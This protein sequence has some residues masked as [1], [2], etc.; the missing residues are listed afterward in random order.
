MLSSNHHEFPGV[1]LEGNARSSSPKIPCWTFTSFLLLR[2][3][4]NQ[5]EN[6]L[7]LTKK[8][9]KKPHSLSCSGAIL[10]Y[11]YAIFRYTL[12]NL[13]WNPKKNGSLDQMFFLFNWGDFWDSK[14]LI[15]VEVWN[16]ENAAPWF[17]PKGSPCMVYLSTWK[18]WKSTIHGSVNIPDR[19]S[20]GSLMGLLQNSATN[21]AI[22][23]SNHDLAV[24]SLEWIPLN[25]QFSG[26]ASLSTCRLNQPIWKIC[27]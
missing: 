27:A 4:A 25:Q 2:R 5:Q 1:F 3:A 7:I 21:S 18:P 23:W 10:C 15:F 24:A 6:V 13:T 16:A 20:H 11:V 9:E 8:N 19:S 26:P 12:N 22:C 17:I 14:M